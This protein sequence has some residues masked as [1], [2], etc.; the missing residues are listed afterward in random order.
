M[1]EEQPSG[2]GIDL[3]H[4]GLEQGNIVRNG[5]EGRAL[6]DGL[7]GPGLAAFEENDAL[8]ERKIGVERFDDFAAAF[9]ASDAG[10]LGFAAVGSLDEIDVGGVDGS[11]EDFDADFAR[12]EWAR[13]G[14]GEL[15]DEGGV[16]A[17]V[18]FERLHGGKLSWNGEACKWMLAIGRNF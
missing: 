12:G 8:S 2:G 18:E 17:G 11:G 4:G 3:E 15:D 13:L 16:A 5:E 10:E 14:S 6:R 9:H 7:G 1:G